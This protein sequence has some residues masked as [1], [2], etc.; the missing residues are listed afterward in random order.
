MDMLTWSYINSRVK[1]AIKKQSHVCHV[2]FFLSLKG[3]LCMYF[4]VLLSMHNIALYILQNK[5]I[6][7]QL[8]FQVFF[9]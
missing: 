4:L 9:F 5:K 1:S 2:F 6:Y 7:A 3:E 8:I